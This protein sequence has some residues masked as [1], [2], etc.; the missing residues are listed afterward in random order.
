MKTQIHTLEY[1]FHSADENPAL[2][3]GMQHNADS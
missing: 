1:K 2:Q 3:L